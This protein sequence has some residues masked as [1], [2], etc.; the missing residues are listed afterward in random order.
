MASG[1]TTVFTNGKQT[2]RCGDPVS[3][4]STV[5]T[6]SSDTFAGDGSSTI[7]SS[8]EIVYEPYYAPLEEII[9][10]GYSE[11]DF[12]SLDDE[13]DVD[14]GLNIWPPVSGTPT[15]EEI[16]RSNSLDVAPTETVEIDDEEP[17]PIDSTAIIECS[18][19]PS[20]VP[21]D[22]Q[23]TTNFNILELTTQAAVSNYTLRPQH[24]LTSQEI[25]CNLLHWC[26]DIGEPLREQY[27]VFLITSGFRHGSG[28]SQHERGQAA[29]LQFPGLSNTQIYNISVWMRDNL[30][31]DQLILEY[32]GNR[33]WIHISYNK[34]G[35][36]S[37]SHDRKCGT[38]ISA[39]NYKWKE[40]INMA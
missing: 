6:C 11:V 23:L 20:I 3:C 29:D 15:Q 16:T 30:D 25:A 40:L 35:N 36:R 17:M 8:G 31:Y 10:P 19:I 38:R 4:G 28:T 33:P 14:D 22:L 2:G 37:A 5:A 34:D 27:G 1:S 21:V 18:G 32:G 24:G 12:A 9:K 39:G 7:N 13:P 26:V